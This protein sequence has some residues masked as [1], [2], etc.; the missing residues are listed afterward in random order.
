MENFAI[1]SAAASGGPSGLLVM[2]K[3]AGDNSEQRHGMTESKAIPTPSKKFLYENSMGP[4]VSL[5]HF[6]IP[7]CFFKLMGGMIANNFQSLD[8]RDNDSRDNRLRFYE[9]TGRRGG[10]YRA[11]DM[12]ACVVKYQADR[13]FLHCLNADSK[14]QEIALAAA[15]RHL[16][17]LHRH[18]NA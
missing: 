9:T 12:S 11:M 7:G 17:F 1:H 10:E 16:R 4:Y 13:M 2:G 18:W 6:L 14:N 8:S 5:Q 15:S 3:G